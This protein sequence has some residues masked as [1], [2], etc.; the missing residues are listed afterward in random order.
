[1]ERRRAFAVCISVYA[2]AG[3]VAL[4][5]GWLCRGLHPIWVAALA[6]LA[7]TVTVFV[8]SMAFDNSSL[9]DPY[10][11]VAPPVIALCWLLSSGGGLVVARVIPLFG[12]LVAWSVRLTGNWAR[13][14]RGIK[15]ED[16]RY[17][18]FRR[19]FGR[20][21]WPVSF[22]GIHLFPTVIVF[23]GCL[24]LY[25]VLGVPTRGF[26]F[27]DA[28][29]IL[30]TALAVWIEATADRQLRR[31][32][33]G[34]A[35]E[36]G[37]APGRALL[38]ERG[39]WSLSRHPNYFGEVLFWWGLYV[40]SL[41]GSPESWWALLGPL[42]VTALFFFVSV[43]MMD[44]HMLERRP[45]YAEAMRTRSGLVPWLPARDKLDEKSSA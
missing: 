42:T 44:R 12:L 6:D 23:L 33:A 43:P 37:A 19:R 32:V 22:L 35:A 9:Y 8:F 30:V 36:P 34:R 10:W 21:Y 3:G 40:F 5:V 15:H 13:G 25:A 39:L 4:G 26:R 41:A 17:V 11:S 14:W 45:E 16:W 28:V 38:F 24:S 2:A 31:F 20:L 27:L 7:A 1:M 29:A 18:E